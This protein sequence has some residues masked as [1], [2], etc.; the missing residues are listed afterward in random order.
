MEEDRGLRR[1][2]GEGDRGLGVAWRWRS[3]RW[4]AW[5]RG[6]GGEKGGG[7]DLEGEEATSGWV[8]FART[9]SGCGGLWMDVWACGGLGLAM[10][11]RMSAM[12]SIR[13][14]DGSTNQNPA[15]VIVFFLLYFLPSYFG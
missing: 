2:L 14:I 3:Q 1:D 12:S 5:V 4:R 10:D 13:V 9:R 6:R 11:G 8:G 15:Y 7:G